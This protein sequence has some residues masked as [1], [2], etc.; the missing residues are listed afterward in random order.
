MYLDDLPA[1]VVLARKKNYV[2]KI[3]I[4][5]IPKHDNLKDSE[6]GDEDF[7]ERP[8]LEEGDD[9]AIYNHLDITV[10]THN[11]FYNKPH[12]NATEFK[13][14]IEIYGGSKFNVTLPAGTVRV[15]GFSVT[16]KSVP[17]G[18]TCSDW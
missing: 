4:G 6:L 5:Y 18:R 2:Q 8:T 11:Q 17:W 3:P 15:V 12:P 9:V 16:P 13:Q 7:Y 1:A 10:T 14:E